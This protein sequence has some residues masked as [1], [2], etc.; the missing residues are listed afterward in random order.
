MNARRVDEA[1]DMVSRN[2]LQDRPAQCRV[3]SS[4]G[5]HG[6][7]HRH[8]LF[9]V[10]RAVVRLDAKL[11]VKGRQSASCR[12]AL[13]TTLY[14]TYD[15]GEALAISDRIV[16]R[17]GR[18]EQIGRHHLPF[19]APVSWRIFCAANIIGRVADANGRFTIG[20]FAVK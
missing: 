10:R 6:A 4:S 8:A 17:T 1:L 19:R 14:V 18:I 2:G 5:R 13:A 9:F 7:G 20:K 15:Q 16:V 3:A 12:P 11:R